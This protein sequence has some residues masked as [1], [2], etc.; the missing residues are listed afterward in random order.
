MIKLET[1]K[2]KVIFH[3]ETN[4]DEELLK[5]LAENCQDYSDKER[6]F[7][8]GELVFSPSSGFGKVDAYLRVIL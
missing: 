8:I 6:T 2:Q 7:D 4:Y 3:A 5:A 1:T